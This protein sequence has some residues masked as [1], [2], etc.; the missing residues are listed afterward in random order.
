MGQSFLKVLPNH[1]DY[2]H[3]SREKVL[4]LS[5]MLLLVYPMRITLQQFLV[6]VQVGQG[7]PLALTCHITYLVFSLSD[8]SHNSGL[9]IAIDPAQLVVAG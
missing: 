3:Y 8:S 5:K 6:S 4:G 7:W 9:G 1:I 2:S